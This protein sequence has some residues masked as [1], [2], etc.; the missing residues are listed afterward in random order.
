MEIITVIRTAVDTDILTL[1]D[2]A[3]VTKPTD[4]R[5]ATRAN[6]PLLWTEFSCI[7]LQMRLEAWE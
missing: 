5:M 7:F 1:L 4:I 2:M 6:A 3:I